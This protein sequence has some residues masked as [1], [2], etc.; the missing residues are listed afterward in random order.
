MKWDS[1]D[2]AYSDFL[3]E[4]QME[5]VRTR[6]EERKQAVVT[7]AIVEAKTDDSKESLKKARE[8]LMQTGWTHAE[9]QKH[10]FN[11]YYSGL[12][13]M[14]WGKFNALASLY[15]LDA[16]AARDELMGPD[17]DYDTEFG[18]WKDTQGE[19]WRKERRKKRMKP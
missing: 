13:G 11:H 1:P 7:S 6:R 16:Q 3:S 4:E 18:R 2:P 15:G 9:A 12:Q 5:Q 17:R 10:L 14:D 19:R 8:R